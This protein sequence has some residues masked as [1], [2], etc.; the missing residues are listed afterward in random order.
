MDA[1]EKLSITL[2]TEMAQELRASV[3]AGEYASTSE[4]LRDA[5]RV[6]KDKRRED[7]EHLVAIRARIRRSLDD[8]RADLSAK[9]VDAHL[10]ALFARAERG[11]APA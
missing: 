9:E 6:W 1:V 4:A 2:T 8:P 7:A 10:A 3:A 11:D 5:V